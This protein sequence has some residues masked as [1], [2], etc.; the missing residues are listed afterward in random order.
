MKVWQAAWDSSALYLWG[1]RSTVHAR[2]DGEHPFA[3]AA[4]EMAAELATLELDPGEECSITLHLPSA[5][6]PFLSPHLAA[7]AG[8]Q[9]IEPGVLKPWRVSALQYDP[10]RAVNFLSSIPNE[11]PARP[12]DSL[13]FWVECTK[14]LLELLCRGRFLP[15]VARKEDG[16]EALWLVLPADASGRLTRAMPASAKA[17]FDLSAEVAVQTFLESCGD[18]LIRSFLSHT[19]LSDSDTSWLHSLTAPSPE[20]HGTAG[21]RVRLE[22]KLRT[23]AGSLLVTN[24]AVGTQT[25][26]RV[27]EENEQWHIDFLL[28]SQSDEK[29]VLSLEALW[30]GE[31]GFLRASDIT[32]QELQESFLRDLAKAR[33]IFPPLGRALAHS[34]P[35]GVEVTL[36]EAYQFLRNAASLLQEAGF[37]VMLPKWW[38]EPVT[39]LGLELTVT[40]TKGGALGLEQLLDFQWQV[41]IGGNVIAE[42]DF[43]RLVGEKRP[44]VFLQGSWVELE[45]DRLRRTLEFLEEARLRKQMKVVDALRFGFGAS[46][47][48]TLL[49]VIG[50]HASGWLKRFLDASKD[51]DF[52]I[53]QPPGFQ[54]S[55]RPYQVQGLS[56]LA[57]LSEIGIGGCLADDMGL[58]K[59]IQ[60]LALLLWERNRN[61]PKRTL[62]VV[63]M[64]ILGNWQREA[65]RF[66]PALKVHLHH[67][68]SRFT[69]TA[70]RRVAEASDV[71]ITTYNLV[72]RDEA[73]ISS[74]PWRRIALDE[75]QNIKNL[76]TKQTKAVRRLAFRQTAEGCDRVAL[77]GTPLENRLDELWSILDFLNPSYLGEISDFRRRFSVPIERFRDKNASER[78]GRLIHPFVLRRLKSDPAVISDLPEKI[79]MEEFVTLSTEQ[80]SLY[81]AA[82]DEMLPQV[83]RS[84][85]MHRKGLVL[86]TITRLKQICDHPALL[87]Q[88][89]H[90]SAVRSGKL[91]RLDELLEVVLA[92]GDRVLLFTQFAQMGHLLQDYLSERFSCDVLFLHGSL[93]RLAREKLVARFQSDDGPQIFV[94]SLK[95]GG[96]GLNLTRANQVIHYDQ[97]WNPAVEQQA[98]DRAHRIGQKESVQVRRLITRGTLE[99]R[100]ASVVKQKMELASAV[101]GSTKSYVTEL[102]VDELRSLLTLAV[103]TRD[104]MVEEEAEEQADE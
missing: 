34:Q 30:G 33:N 89:K 26:F 92:E 5:D 53:D 87:F 91:A 44:L 20:L 49:P 42:E 32:A 38:H 72:Y 54:G 27:R 47:D 8:E 79:E 59:T 104:T 98:T 45:P 29:Q 66:T 3:L 96:Y 103:E 37:K 4:S 58:G 69:G 88:E 71:V 83:A 17:R 73:L 12:D 90:A 19:P 56:W 93:P 62:L 18:A 31:R 97:W 52:R 57:F 70:F 51:W 14:L 55:L 64:S 65:E 36:E 94:L 74:V 15:S 2:A 40:G 99:E 76:S 101:V 82:L 13:L 102:S 85:G 50:F 35:A 68:T 28:L 48:P 84:S 61:E 67:G 16:Y 6:A 39:K 63:P 81:Q 95:A 23:W 25:A 11:L 43:R 75:A 10:L 86:A 9:N 7:S 60:F 78:L 41:S 80:A 77:T 21:E 22:Q 1:E 46:D 24:R 100:I